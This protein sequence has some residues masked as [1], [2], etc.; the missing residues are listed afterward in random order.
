M[1]LSLKALKK[2]PYYQ[3]VVSAGIVIDNNVQISKEELRRIKRIYS[4]PK[5]SCGSCNQVI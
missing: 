1:I 5:Q 2:Q 4:P 3:D